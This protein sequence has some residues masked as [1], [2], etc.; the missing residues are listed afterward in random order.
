MPVVK[1]MGLCLLLLCG[2]AGGVMLV[3]YERRRYAQAEGFLT[4]LRTVRLDIDCFSMPVERILK[5]CDP[6][7]LADCGVT[8]PP[9][10]FAVLL[11]EANLCLPR[12][13]CRLLWD[14]SA[15]LGSSYREE[16]LRCCD[17]YLARL[18]P[19]CDKLRAELPKREKTA[20]LLPVAVAAVLLLMLL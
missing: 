2:V 16:Q 10:D 5:Q 15:Q 8:R 18:A 20:F 17:Y 14:F 19:F 9:E 1:W 11:R 4:L 13:I 7:L 6:H 3:R 12:E